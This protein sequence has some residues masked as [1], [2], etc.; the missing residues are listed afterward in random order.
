MDKKSSKNR[1]K[2]RNPSGSVL[3][4]MLFLYDFY[5]NNKKPVV[6]CEGIF[7]AMRLNVY[8]YRAMCIFGTNVSQEQIDLLNELDVKEVILCLDPDACVIKIDKKGKK[9][10]K[11]LK[12]A[13]K[14][15]NFFLG[16]VSIMYL[17]DD[18]PDDSSEEEVGR[19]FIDRQKLSDD[20]WKLKK[21]LKRAKQGE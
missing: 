12:T 19:A 2:T 11:A 9:T 3:S 20:K 1:P 10:S 8:G 6:L 21:A 15:N 17:R 4:K 13:K 16:G 7:D 18:D 5:P 14:I